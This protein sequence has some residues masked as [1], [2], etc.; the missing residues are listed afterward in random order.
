MLVSFIEIKYYP[1]GRIRKSNLCPGVSGL[2]A[3]F[4]L[5]PTGEMR[6]VMGGLHLKAETPFGTVKAA[7]Y[8][9][10]MEFKDGNLVTKSDGT[11]HNSLRLLHISPNTSPISS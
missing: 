9:G 8:F 5:S 7:R 3:A 4:I 11:D 10:Y 2:Q 1:T 6:E